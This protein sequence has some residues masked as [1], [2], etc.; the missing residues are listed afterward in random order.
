MK[1]LF[2]GYEDSPLIHFIKSFGDS[3]THDL[4][5]DADFLISYGYAK[6]LKR[7]ELERFKDRAINLHISYLPWNRGSDPNL[8]SFID[9][10]PKG[11]TIHL[12][13]ERLDTGNI[14]AQREVFIPRDATLK[15]SYAILRGEIEHLFR[16]HWSKIRL[17]LV[18][19]TPQKGNGSYHRSKDKEPMMKY[20]TRGWDTPVQELKNMLRNSDE[21]ATG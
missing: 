20:L 12:M 8:W 11:V 7:E 10:T 1:V 5:E 6:I 17:G 4:K 2:L 14:L 13:D 16:D 19:P 15:I 21:T 9:D 3:V 18:I